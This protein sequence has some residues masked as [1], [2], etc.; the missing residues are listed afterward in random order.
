MEKIIIAAVSLNGVIGING[1]LPWNIE[2]DL[3]F[4][5][6]TTYGFPIVM[7]YNTFKSFINPLEG[8]PNIVITHKK[9]NNYSNVFFLNN[10]KD[11]LNFAESLNNKKL[12]IIGGSK[13]FEQTIKLADNLIISRIKEEYFGDARFPTINDKDWQ[14]NFIETKDQFNIEFY[15]KK[16]N[17][18]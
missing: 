11:A 17:E 9:L 4:F 8:R 3:L 2:S 6:N 18:N 10:V 13:I 15:R 1:K 12:F 14:L 16:I 7:G 5:K